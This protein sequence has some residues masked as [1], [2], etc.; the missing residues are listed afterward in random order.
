MK[1]HH[2]KTLYPIKIL[3]VLI[4][5]GIMFCPAAY[6]HKASIF[7]W[8]QGDTIHTQSKLM[9]GKRPNQA[10]VEVFDEN[11]NLLLKGRTDA[12]GQFSFPVPQKSNLKI[13]LNA[14]AGHLA[15]WSLTPNDF[16]DAASDSS[17]GHTHE[18]AVY[19]EASQTTNGAHPD[20][21]TR[22]EIATL[23]A[24]ALDQKLGP[25]MAKLAEMD[26]NRIKPSD[27]IG[28]LGYIIGLVGLAAYIR[29]HSKSRD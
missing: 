8:V 13:V 10:L 12:R 28:G 9:G 19:T 26:Q 17:H 4:M 11:Q 6:A 25:V 14:G 22:E 16:M 24:A 29:Y 20:L 15:Y 1:F 21:V 3:C 27:I 7:A 18:S 23:V 5:A 2:Q